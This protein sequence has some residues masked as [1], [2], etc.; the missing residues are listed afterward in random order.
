MNDWRVE[1]MEIV[2]SIHNVQNLRKQISYKKKTPRK[3]VLTESKRSCNGFS[4]KNDIRFPFFIHGETRQNFSGKR[5]S[6][7]PKNGSTF[8]C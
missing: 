1:R 2:E 3:R 5:V 4:S 6:V 8:G 7:T